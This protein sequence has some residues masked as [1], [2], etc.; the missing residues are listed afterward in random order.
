MLVDEFSANSPSHTM[1]SPT[2]ELRALDE[3]AFAARVEPH[4]REL[5]VHCYRLLGYPVNREG[6]L[7]DAESKVLARLGRS[8]AGSSA[9]LF[10]G[11]AIRDGS[12]R[13][14][15]HCRNYLESSPRGGRLM[16]RCPAAA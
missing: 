14:R 10:T 16:R 3:Q 4:R 2:D 6:P 5:H 1:N 13:L 11:R 9:G 12:P 7:G 8:A 15:R